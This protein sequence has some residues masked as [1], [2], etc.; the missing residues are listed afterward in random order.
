M[1]SFDA[2]VVGGGPAGSTCAWRLVQA[3]LHVA[4]LD[5]VRFPRVKLCGGWVSPPVWD[6]LELD[7]RNYPRGL[8]HWR[9]VHVEFLGRMYTLRGEGWFIRR[10]ELDDFLLQRS[11]AQVHTHRVQDIE[12]EGDQWVVDSAFRARFLIG[13]G[14]TNCP[15]ARKLFP[16]KER[17]P[18][19]TQEREFEADPASVAARR[20]GADGEPELL[21]HEDLGGYSWNVPKTG[22]LNVGSGT[23]DP[24]AV[25]P[26][27]RNARSFFLESGH[28]PLE[29]SAALEEA[30]GHSYH[31]FRH[32][33]LEGAAREGAALVGD[34][35]GLAHPL[36]GEGILPAII[37]GRVC[38]EALLERRL[39]DY[40]RA[41]QSHPLFQ[42]YRII[43]ALVR[44][45]SRVSSAGNGR[46]STLAAPV[47]ARAFAYAFSARPLPGRRA[48]AKALDLLQR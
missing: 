48:V 47:V 19:G 7:P 30:K 13:A 12:R 40:P 35:L 23:V 16:R 3:G 33:H 44:A 8:W 6:A 38:A 28:L 22:W 1:E 25:L 29:S 26:A 11:G 32:Q 31:L 43:E 2:L 39:H 46:L 18:V 34:A 37:S 17:K 9:R 21:L 15:V 24:K 20:L 10:Y 4:V 27:W 36:T 14:G 5:A 42:D 45:A 41:L